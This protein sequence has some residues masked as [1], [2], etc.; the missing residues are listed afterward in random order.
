VWRGDSEASSLILVDAVELLARVPL[1]AALPDA[2]LARV[3]R[4]AVAERVEGGATFIRQGERGDSIHIIRAGRVEVLVDGVVVR[5]AGRGEVVGEFALL[6]GSVRS[7]TVRA[8][9]D[10]EFL[11]LSGTAFEQLLAT[12]HAFSRALIAQLADRLKHGDTRL[13]GSTNRVLAVVAGHPG[14]PAARVD[15]ISAKL[16]DE[17][18]GF[19]PVQRLRGHETGPDGWPRLLDAAESDH[20]WTLLIAGSPGEWATFSCRQADRVL[21]VVDPTVPV[22]AHPPAARSLELVVLGDSGVAPWLERWTP[23]THHLLPARSVDSASRLA[24]RVAGRSVGIVL[25]GGGARGFAH[26]GVLNALRDAG[27]QVDRVGGTSMGAFIAGMVARGGSSAEIRDVIERE[28]VR[29]NP[30]RDYTWPRHSLIRAERART[31]LERVFG[32]AHIEDQALP[33]FCVSTD[34]VGAEEVVHRRGSMADAIGMSMSLP[35]IAPPRRAGPRLHVDGG[36]LNNLPVDV[37]AADAEGPV[38]AVDVMRPFA[39]SNVTGN[40]SLPGIVDTIG[41]S[42]V[43]GS[44]RKAED[45]RRMASLVITPRLDGVGM[46]DFAKVDDIVREGRRVAE[47]ELSAPG[48]LGAFARPG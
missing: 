10:T 11:T 42:M 45:C 37:M 31:L 46:F 27:V 21:A 36:V 44:W 22:P 12:E 39:Q 4:G 20:A 41:R 35:G 2:V 38:I 18:S 32:G 30:F 43:L 23:R 6:G 8:I 7:G 17:L 5:I 16:A 25:S 29:H 26:L 33:M 28:I 47:R 34:L 15:E 48:V 13:A 24:R 3:A 14:L 40:A 1:F 9:R 19:G